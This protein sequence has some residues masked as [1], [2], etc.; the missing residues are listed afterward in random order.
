MVGAYLEVCLVNRITAKLA[1]STLT[2]RRDGAARG[3]M[4][5]ERERGEKKPVVKHSDCHETFTIASAFFFA[6]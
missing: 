6:W 5:R 3:K 4:R 1:V 2:R